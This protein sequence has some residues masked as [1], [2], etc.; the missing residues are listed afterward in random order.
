MI[1][2]PVTIAYLK[3]SRDDVGISALKKNQIIGYLTYVFLV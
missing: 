1:M 2:L 3:G